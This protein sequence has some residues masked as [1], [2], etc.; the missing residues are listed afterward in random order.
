MHKI[1]VQGQNTSEIL[2]GEKL[3]NLSKYLPKGKTIIITDE[4]IEKLYK[5]QFPDCPVIVLKPGEANK[6]LQSIDFISQKLIELE[7]DRS[8]FLVG[9]GGGIIC[10]ITGF[11]A[12]IFMRGL[13]FGFVST[14]LLA[15]VDASVGGKNGVNFEGYKNILGVFNQPEFVIC[16]TAM[17]KTLPKEELSCGFAEIIKHTLIKDAEMF[18][19]LEQNVEKALSLDSETIDLL[20]KHSVETKANVVNQDE[21]EKGERRKLNFGHTLGHAIEKLTQCQHGKAVGIGMM[22]AAK[23]SVQKN[24]LAETELKRI[25]NLLKAYQ[26]PVNN[27]LPADSLF[28][29]MK[30]DKKKTGESLHFIL[31]TKIGEAVAEE[32]SYNELLSQMKEIY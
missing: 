29:A 16:D 5:S 30:K 8:T 4:N 26:L 10:D 20:V 1:I 28:N 11:V 15:Q 14:T 19:F 13:R 31:L 21:R 7:A 32:I 27:E 6:T 22:F 23:L 2:V 12:S 25:E 9:I 3:E 24:Y 17:L 18:A